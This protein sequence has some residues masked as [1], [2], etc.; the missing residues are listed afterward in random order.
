MFFNAI[1]PRHITSGI[2]RKN[3]E[4]A[5]RAFKLAFPH[6]GAMLTLKVSGA[7]SAPRELE[8]L[9]RLCADPAIH[10]L[11]KTLSHEE[12]DNL[13][14]QHDV[15]LSLHRSEGYGLTIRE[16]MLRGLHVVATG[17]SGNMDFM[18]GSL[19]HAVPF[20]MVPIHESKG[21]LKGLKGRWAEPDADAAAMV[22]RELAMTLR[23]DRNNP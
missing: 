12:L 3:P 17:W 16:A 2:S 6:G 18:T 4:A 14:W 8:R 10:I 9:R 5:I 22:L 19:A 1:A 13:Y 23:Q 20:Q 15:Y 7:A 21:P 11:T